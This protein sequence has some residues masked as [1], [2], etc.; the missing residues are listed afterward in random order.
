MHR[1]LLGVLVK[2]ALQPDHRGLQGLDCRL[3]RGDLGIVL[4]GFGPHG[5]VRDRSAFLRVPETSFVVGN[6]RPAAL[7]MV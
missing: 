2:L 7:L 5:R 1:K 6:G 4:G 3:Q